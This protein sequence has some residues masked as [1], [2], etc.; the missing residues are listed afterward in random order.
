MHN[1]MDEPKSPREEFESLAQQPPS[2]LVRDFIDFLRTNKRWWLAP[3]LVVLVILSVMIM[4][5]NTAVGPF[6]YVLF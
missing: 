4:V 1:P 3:L 2:G 6:I 5:T